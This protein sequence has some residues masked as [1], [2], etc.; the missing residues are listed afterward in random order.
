MPVVPGEPP[1]ARHSVSRSGLQ[2]KAN[3]AGPG[4]NRQLGVSGV[5]AHLLGRRDRVL[6]SDYPAWGSGASGSDVEGLVL[7]ANTR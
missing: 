7:R 2:W 5:K 1:K 3:V 4:R 6:E